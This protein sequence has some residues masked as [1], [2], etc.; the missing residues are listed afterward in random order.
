[1]SSPLALVGL[2]IGPDSPV[3]EAV[4]QVPHEFAQVHMGLP[5]RIRLY[6]ASEEAAATG[7]A[8]AF[9]RV[10]ALDQMMSDYRPEIGRAHV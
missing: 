7:A 3:P 1:M 9:A 2:R 10:A 5:V 8:A 6:S 4:S